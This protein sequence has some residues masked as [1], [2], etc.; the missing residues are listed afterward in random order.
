MLSV[1]IEGTLL[2]TPVQRTS[3]KGTPFV[4]VQ[5]RCS[6]DDGASILCSVIAFQ[7]SVVEALAALAGGD[8]VAVAGLGALS[9][10]E[11]NGE[12]HVGLKVT[13]SRVLTVYDAGMRRKAASQRQEREAQNGR[14]AASPSMSSSSALP[15]KSRPS[16]RFQPHGLSLGLVDM[17][18]DE[19]V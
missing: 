4:T 3:S 6:G 2:G 11:K 12:H 5:L 19:P 18:N 10:W 9:Q 7:A 14:V 15:G 1:L 16:E 8:T 13:A 17:E